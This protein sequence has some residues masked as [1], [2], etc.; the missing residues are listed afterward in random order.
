MRHAIQAS[1]RLTE[2]GA[3]NEDDL[4][5]KVEKIAYEW[6]GFNNMHR[7]THWM[8]LPEPPK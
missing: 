1:G 3:E 8:P 2:I 7:A 5:R 6:R 4:Y